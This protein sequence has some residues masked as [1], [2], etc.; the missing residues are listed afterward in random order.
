MFVAGFTTSRLYS[1]LVAVTRFAGDLLGTKVIL[2]VTSFNHK[3]KCFS[4][5]F[6]IYF[7]ATY[8]SNVFLRQ[9]FLYCYS[10]LI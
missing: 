4:F 7:I 5:I 6:S 3:Y 1:S 2:T 8:S 10:S 9:L